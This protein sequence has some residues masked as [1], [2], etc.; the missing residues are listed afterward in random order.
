MDNKN[1]APDYQYKGW[2]VCHYVTPPEQFIACRGEKVVRA[3]SQSEIERKIEDAI[4]AEAK[5]KGS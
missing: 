5:G 2:R 3:G 4:D 1:W